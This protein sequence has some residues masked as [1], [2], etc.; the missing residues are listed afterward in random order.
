MTSIHFYT[1]FQA[2]SEN[3]NDLYPDSNIEHT[4]IPFTVTTGATMWSIDTHAG[5]VFDIRFEDINIITPNGLMPQGSS[6]YSKENTSLVELFCVFI[7]N[8]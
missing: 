4:P 5:N 1:K 3:D 8:I 6:I 2:V 7:A